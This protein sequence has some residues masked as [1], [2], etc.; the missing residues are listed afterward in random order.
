MAVPTDKTPP[1]FALP[2]MPD[3]SGSGYLLEQL[4][5]LNEGL[6]AYYREQ[7][8]RA[9]PFADQFVNRWE[10]ARFLGFGEGSSIYDNALVLGDVTVGKS[11]W[12]GPGCILDGSGGLVIGSHCSVAAGCQIYTHDSIEWALSG[13]RRPYVRRPTVIGDACYLA[14]HVVV[15][16]GVTIGAHCLVGALSLV[17]GDLPDCSIAAGIPARIVG[18]VELAEDGTVTLVYHSAAPSGTKV[19]A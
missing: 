15:A 16:A 18:R 11:T 19:S 10:K 8:R 1:R 14:P 9:L 2:D 7:F 3:R 6:R 12:I 17:K 4:V 13:G 5:H